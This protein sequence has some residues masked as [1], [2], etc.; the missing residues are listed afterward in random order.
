MQVRAIR[1]SDKYV[2][3][4][5]SVVQGQSELKLLATTHLPLG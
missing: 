3:D 2:D 1:V 4:H 5:V